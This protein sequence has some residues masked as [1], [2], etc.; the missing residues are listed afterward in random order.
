MNVT[1]GSG[2]S[3]GAFSVGEAVAVG[4]TVG[5]TEGGGCDAFPLQ[6]T[7]ASATSRAHA[8]RPSSRFL[9]AV[10]PL[11]LFSNA[12]NLLVLGAT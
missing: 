12:R 11:G 4:L 5:E 1:G 7:A 2:S 9:G 8:T 6:A 3:V 10:R